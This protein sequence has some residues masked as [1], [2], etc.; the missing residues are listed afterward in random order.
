MKFKFNT[1]A[2]REA[3]SIAARA[4]AAQSTM[5]AYQEVC[6]DI[7]NKKAIIRA[8]NGEM[9]I[10]TFIEEINGESGKLSIET[11]AILP[12]VSKLTGEETTLEKKENQLIIR[13]GKARFTL[14]LSENAD[15]FP[16]ISMD[17]SIGEFD[18]D[19]N[20]LVSMFKGTI[21]CADTNNSQALMRSVNFKITNG[22]LTLVCLD[23]HRVAKRN[24]EV[25]A[26]DVECNIPVS[27]VKALLSFVKKGNVAIK[28]GKNYASFKTVNGEIV[29]RLT[30]G[31]FFNIENIVNVAKTVSV[32]IN[33]RDLLETIERATLISDLI[34]NVP[35]ILTFVDDGINVSAKSKLSDMDEMVSCNIQKPDWEK[36]GVN[37][38]YLVD[39]LKE[40]GDETITLEFT[41]AKA[42]V[43]VTGD[44]YIYLVLPVNIR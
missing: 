1:V 11:K 29:T 25:T 16:T 6:F 10:S 15:A 24:A 27:A 34:N 33:R 44:E 32:Q 17:T 30:D 18:I 21:F 4:N 3:I 26:K 12:I 22:V 31:K 19:S 20:L 7:A 43:F 35:V 23:G 37:P 13:S 28:I 2:L 8:L 41:S 39:L 5:K 36:L 14:T 38:R 9:G 40:I 42:P